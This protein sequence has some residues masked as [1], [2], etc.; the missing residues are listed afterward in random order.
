MKYV[1]TLIVA[2][3]LSAAP[4]R[5]RDLVIGGIPEEPNRWT[6]EG[7]K[8]S[9][10]DVDII[11]HVMKKLG[12][13]YRIELV[14]SSARLE[15]NAKANPAV[16]DMVFTYSRN[17]ERAKYLRYAKE[18]HISFNWNFFFL[19]ENQGKYSFNSYQD[20]AKWTIGITKGFSYSD[21]FLKAIKEIPLRVDE[22][23]K[24][25]QQLDKLLGKRFDLVPLNTKA[26]LWEARQRGVLNRIAYLP[27]PVKDVAYYNT[28]V[29]ASNYPGLN[30]IADRYDEVIRQMKK[31]GTLAQILAKYEA[32]P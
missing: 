28:F 26:T 24:N 11:D 25:E 23:A 16:Y 13:A 14:G 15:A 20:L 6:A 3:V 5:A 22:V 19:R 8:V 32:F 4:A 29:M 1:V 9:G 7:D 17:D 31:D 2:C 21:E 10:I 12:I 30:D 27:K 18:S